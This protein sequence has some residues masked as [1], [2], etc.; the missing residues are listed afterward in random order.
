MKKTIPIFIY[1]AYTVLGIRMMLD[2][3]ADLNNIP[4]NAESVGEGISS[5]I[6]AGFLTL[7]SIIFMIYAAASA[8]ALLFN[9]LHIGTGFALFGAICVLFDLL[10]AAAYGV[11]LYYT[12]IGEGLSE[13]IAIFAALF[14]SALASMFSNASSLSK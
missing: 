5:G 11:I 12:V 3:R 1:L 6:S 8:V 7:F 13:G 4:E 2:T 14:L 10:F 9:L